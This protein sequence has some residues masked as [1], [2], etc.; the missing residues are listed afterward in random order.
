M[1]QAQLIEQAIIHLHERGKNYRQALMELATAEYNYKTAK[2]EA[3]LKAD[4]TI[5]DKEA[6]AEQ[7]VK[8][9]YLTYL[10]AEAEATFTKASLDDC[11]TVI[12]ARQSI[13]SAESKA[14]TLQDNHS[15]KQ[16]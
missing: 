8:D 1:R 9:L 6:I 15:F 10:T 4:G 16:I 12:S 2:S 7:Q 3:Y 11:R 13:L 5:K 14:N